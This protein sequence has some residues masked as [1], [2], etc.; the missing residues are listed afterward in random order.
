MI[1]D[2]GTM[3]SP[4]W[5]IAATTVPAPISL[6]DLGGRPVDAVAPQLAGVSDLHLVVHDGDPHRLVGLALD[7]HVVPAGELQLGA[8]VAAHVAGAHQVAW[9][10]RSA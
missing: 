7:D 6:D 2:C 9:A 1:T 3:F 4:A 10:R 8:P 5:P